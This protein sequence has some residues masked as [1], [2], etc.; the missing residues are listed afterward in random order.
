MRSYERL[1]LENKAWA[2]ERVEDDPEFFQ[3]LK[4]L[5]T[6]EYLWI[7]CSDS[8]VPANEITGTQPGEIFV[9]RNIANM[10]VH[11]DLNLLSVLEYAV[12]HLGVNNIILCGHTGCGGIKAA[13]SG[14]NFDLLNK[15]LR[16]VKDVYYNHRDEIQ[17]IK[18]ES[19]KVNRMVELNVI[20]QVNNLVKTSVVQKA[21]LKRKSPKI[22]G[23]IYDM[24]TGLLKS[25]VEKN[26]ESDIDAVF[27]FTD[28]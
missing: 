6:P 9:H 17:S 18:S 22:H 19:E 13:L 26:F 27:R 3:R 8:R 23:W 20:E 21:W 11:T 4:N 12:T 2:A 28:L 10:V 1:L 14:A 5:Q 16:N 7:G 15:W 25:V 24:E